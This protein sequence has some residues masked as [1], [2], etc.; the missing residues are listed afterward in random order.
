LKTLIILQQT[1]SGNGLP[2][3]IRVARV[4]RKTLQKHFGLIFSGHTV[5]CEYHRELGRY[6]AV[7]QFCGSQYNNSAVLYIDDIVKIK[8][9]LL[10]RIRILPS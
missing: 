10:S 5:Q 7:K 3:F 2:D 8:V 4:L 6:A 1:Y 9:L